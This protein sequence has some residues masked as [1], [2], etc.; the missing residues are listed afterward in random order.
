MPDTTAL[1]VCA[2]M[3]LVLLTSAGAVKRRPLF[4]QAGYNPWSENKPQSRESHAMAT[5]PDGSIY[6]FGGTTSGGTSNDFFKLD[7]EMGTWSSIGTSTAPSARDDH[8]MTMVGEDLYVF[9]GQDSGE[10]GGVE[11]RIGHAWLPCCVRHQ[12]AGSEGGCRA[13]SLPSWVAMSVG[14]RGCCACRDRQSGWTYEA[15]VGPGLG[16]GADLGCCFRS[17]IFRRAVQVLDGHDDVD[18]AGRGGRRDGHGAEWTIW[19]QHDDGGGG[20]LRLRRLCRDNPI[21]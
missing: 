8:S 15:V 7:T 5:G 10:A 19:P 3:L 17:N 2:W 20:P 1:L 4:R 9:G 14:G 21:R 11:G 16:G 12:S 18:A 6:M 13:G